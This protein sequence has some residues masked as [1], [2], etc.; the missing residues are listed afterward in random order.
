MANEYRVS[1]HAVE[2]LHSGPLAGPARVSAQQLMVL[3]PNAPIVQVNGHRYWR[4]RGT[5]TMSGIRYGWGMARIFGLGGENL[6]CTGTVATQF[7]ATTGY[8]ASQDE[9]PST[10]TLSSDPIVWDF[11]AGWAVVID[12]YLVG[13]TTSSPTESVRGWVLE[14]SD[15]NIAWVAADTQ[16]LVAAWTAGEVRRYNVTYSGGGGGGGSRKKLIMVH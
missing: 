10:R 7:D 4:L 1:T 3:R 2:V 9:D 14:Y 8:G 15:D 6:P 12:Y 13:G 16:A 11:G 5:L